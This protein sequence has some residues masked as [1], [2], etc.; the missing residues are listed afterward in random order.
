MK[1][2]VGKSLSVSNFDV[3]GETIQKG[4]KGYLYGE[5][6]VWRPGDT[7]FLSFMMNDN[8]SKLE[9]NHP[10]KFKLSDPN[11]KTMYQ[12]VQKYDEKNHYKFTV[13]TRNWEAVVILPLTQ[14]LKPEM[15]RC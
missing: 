8:A 12:I 6:S 10:V 14:F 11:G 2:D 1:L 13:P 3:S 9:K 4:I 5:R 15:A 7:L